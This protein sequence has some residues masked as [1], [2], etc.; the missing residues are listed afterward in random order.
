MFSRTGSQLTLMDAATTETQALSSALSAVQ[1]KKFFL[2]LSDVN[3]ALLVN[4]PASEKQLDNAQEETF[5]LFECV[6]SDR[7]LRVYESQEKVA[8]NKAKLEID[9]SSADVKIILPSRKSAGNSANSHAS[10]IGPEQRGSSEKPNES[11]NFDIQI[12]WSANETEP[13]GADVC[14]L[15]IPEADIHREWR[16]LVALSNAAF[17]VRC[18]TFSEST[19]EATRQVSTASP[20]LSCMTRG[21]FMQALQMFKVRTLY[22]NIFLDMQVPYTCAAIRAFNPYRSSTE[23]CP[24]SPIYKHIASGS[25]KSARQLRD[26]IPRK[27][28]HLASRKTTTDGAA[29][30]SPS[31]M[32][33]VPHSDHDAKGG[34]IDSSISSK[35][36]EEM[37]ERNSLAA[38]SGSGRPRQSFFSRRR[39]KTVGAALADEL[40]GS[41]PEPIVDGDIILDQLPFAFTAD[42]EQDELRGMLLSMQSVGWRR[43]DVLFGSIMSHEHIIAKRANLDK[44]LDSGAD[45]VHHV[46]DTFVL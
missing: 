32:E 5:E 11:D 31:N 42:A 28:K 34:N 9:M 26:T 6:L 12:R 45:V 2:A 38:S 20:L 16:W 13:A 36:Y 15:R 41:R 22:S 18:L 35:S 25:L 46:M 44:L 8:E 30:V 29:L 27:I 23:K 1:N 10:F 21:Q 4:F 24:M 14:V 39:G 33:D 19:N 43:I 3:G 17:G 7:K 40:C 37:A